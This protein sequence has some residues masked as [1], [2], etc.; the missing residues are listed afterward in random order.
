M[1]LWCLFFF[2]SLQHLCHH[3]LPNLVLYLCLLPTSCV[4]F[5]A[6]LLLFL[7][8]THVVF[9]CFFF[10][11]LLYSFLPCHALPVMHAT[12]TCLPA[13]TYPSSMFMPLPLSPAMPPRMPSCVSSSLP[14]TLYSLPFYSMFCCSHFSVPYLSC[15]SLT[16]SPSLYCY[17]SSKNTLFKHGMTLWHGN[18]FSFVTYIPP[19]LPI[20]ANEETEHDMRQ[21]LM[22]TCRRVGDSGDIVGGRED[23]VGRCLEGGWCLKWKRLRQDDDK[24]DVIIGIALAGKAGGSWRRGSIPPISY[25]IHSF[26]AELILLRLFSNFNWV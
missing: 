14:L 22:E 15:M 20:L 9:R 4:L 12:H 11:L 24:G 7:P 18:T 23:G 8:P 21:T 25:S 26:F 1:G 5:S 19:M 2:L 17:F 10:S 3:S 16:S 13:H 6:T